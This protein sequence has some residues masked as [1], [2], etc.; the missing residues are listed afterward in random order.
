MAPPPTGLHCPEE[1]HR[2]HRM[3]GTLIS[4]VVRPSQILERYKM[5]RAEDAE[6]IDNLIDFLQRY[7]RDEIGELAQG[8]PRD[9]RSL[10]V[11]H[12]DVL[13]YDTEIADDVLD[14]PE[15]MRAHFEEALRLYDLPVDLDLRDAHVR[16][17][18]L[19]ETLDV[20]EVSRHD[21]IGDLLDVRGQ[22]QKVSKVRPRILEATFECQRCGALTDIP[23]SGES[24][25]EPHECSGCE[26]R[27]PFDHHSELSEWTDHQYARFQQPPEQTHG[28]D[29][30]TIDVH[31]EDDLTKTFDAGDRVTLTG[32]LEVEEPTQ[33]QSRSF[34]TYLSARAVV[35]EES[36]YEDINV[37]D[38]LD[39]VRAIANG[40][41]GNPYDLLVGTVNPKHEGDEMIKL[42]IAL[43]LFGGWPHEFPDGNRD[44]GDWHILLLGDPGCGKSTFLQWVDEIA[45]RSTY[46]SGKGA[47]AA[48]MTAAAVADDFGDTDW[49][50]E[51]G[52]LVL[53]DGGV[54]CIDEIDKMQDDAVSSMHDALESQQVQINKAGINATLN[55]RSALLAAG[56]PKHG[57]FDP[58]DTKAEQ[59]DLGPTLLSRFDLLFMVSDAPDADRDRNVVNHMIESRQAAAKYTRGE[60]LSAEETNTIE[61][62]IERE[63]LRAYIAHA[64]ESCQPVLKDDAVK[65][66][67]KEYFVAFRQGTS[68]DDDNPVPITYR[69]VEAVQR[70]AE[71]SA[72]V[73]LSETI[74]MEDVERAT[75]LVESSMR[76]VGYDPETDQ[77]DVDIIETGTSTSQ[78]N[79]HTTLLETLKASGG[80]SLEELDDA[81]DISR[82]TLEHDVEHLKDEG[83]IYPG[84]GDVLRKA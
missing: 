10:Y 35:R 37:D 76:Q 21:N 38:H 20:N 36:D 54:A 70:I 17:Y 39:E 27:A 58:Y 83:R 57:R 1:S 26:T 24:L 59:I 15:Q 28:G 64:K 25:Q 50:L 51:A 4:G 53:A 2:L 42:T 13:Q 18:N 16:F 84:D 75:D 67:L 52:A 43:Q 56:N 78:R 66:K 80:M 49:S 7:Y 77:F 6:L 29:S 5:P 9:R 33:D 62:A 81:L 32:L 55:A 63:V 14:K 73:R 69:K 22:V 23:Q 41:R 12:T 44:R 8:Y 79:R 61:P 72:R 34:E 47:S 45:P 65:E 19:P 71:A 31:L 74:E 68:V 46:A 30:Q 40:E 11:D 82:N 48:G 60:E 3:G